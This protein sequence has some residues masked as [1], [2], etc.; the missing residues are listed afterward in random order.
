MNIDTTGE[1][2]S[3]LLRLKNELTVPAAGRSASLRSGVS[4]H[5]VEAA[6]RRLDEDHYGV[7]SVCF[8][9]IPRAELL[10]RPYAETCLACRSRH[11]R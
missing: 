10:R 8:L 9:V 6:L 1:F 4:F 5:Q 3:A 2:R 7:C 11:A